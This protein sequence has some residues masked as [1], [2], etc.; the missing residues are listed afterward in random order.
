MS[1][2]KRS[3]VLIA[4]REKSSRMFAGS[5][6]AEIEDVFLDVTSCSRAI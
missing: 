1:Q 4:G 2:D 3:K 5:N 6:D